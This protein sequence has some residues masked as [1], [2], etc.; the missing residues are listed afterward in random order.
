MVT[1]RVWKEEESSA[2]YGVPDTALFTPWDLPNPTDRMP[3]LKNYHAIHYSDAGGYAP[4]PGFG[5]FALTSR[6]L[7][8]GLSPTSNDTD[9]DGLYDGP[10][11]SWQYASDGKNHMGEN[12]TTGYLGEDD[13]YL[14]DP[15]RILGD[16]GDGILTPGEP[17]LQCHPLNPD[18]DGDSAN[19]GQEFFGYDLV[20]MSIAAD[21]SVAENHVKG[22]KS[23]PLD[24]RNVIW[25]S[26]TTGNKDTTTT[27]QGRDLDGD[28]ITDYNEVHYAEAYPEIVNW[29]KV[30]R[31]E[32]EVANNSYKAGTST[33]NPPEFNATNYLSNQFNPFVKENTPPVITRVEIDTWDDWGWCGLIPVVE[34]SWSKIDLYAMDLSDFT[35]RMG[36]K[37]RNRY[38]E[39]NGQ[40][41]GIE[42]HFTTTIEIDYWA[43]SLAEYYVNATLTDTAGNRA[44]YEKEVAGFFGDVMNFLGD[45][46]NGIVGVFSAAWEAVK[47]AVNILGKII[48]GTIHGLLSPILTPIQSGIF[49]LIERIMNAVNLDLTDGFTL[50]KSGTPIN[51][52][53]FSRTEDAFLALLP[54][55]IA[56]GL[57]ISLAM[58]VVNLF[59]VSMPFLIPLITLLGLGLFSFLIDI[60]NNSDTS[61]GIVP[62]SQPIDIADIFGD[63]S[64]NRNQITADEGTLWIELGVHFAAFLSW[65]L[66][67]ILLTDSGTATSDYDGFAWMVTTIALILSLIGSLGEAINVDIIAFSFSIVSLIFASSGIIASGIGLML[68]WPL[69][70]W[71]HAGLMLSL[72]IA[73]MIIWGLQYSLF[74]RAWAKLGA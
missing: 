46:W 2:Y 7:W 19:D 49:G 60:S 24:A 8:G 21:G 14:G 5:A 29:T 58:Y 20:W 73:N 31:A 71:G 72:L 37:D 64:H 10:N 50:A 44:Y 68:D 28:G 66:S 51:E 69:L 15:Y 67:M 59:V 33:E 70:K 12:Y 45:V 22:V 13:T 54:M 41:G 56:F 40:G 9:G 34:A 25:S 16:D 35:V 11:V 4:L 62:P 17:W 38:V 52:I 39:F 18:T 23:D 61:N 48:I 55:I 47:S 53:K 74:V 42:R 30:K 3:G 26:T 65:F 6:E 43:D 27:T 1:K 32:W 57:G 36:V 63:L